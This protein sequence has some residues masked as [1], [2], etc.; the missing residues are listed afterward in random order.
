MLNRMRLWLRANL[1]RRRMEREMREEMSAHIERSTERLVK[2]G[3]SLDEARQQA[4]REFGNVPY[5]QEEARYA[6]GTIWLDAL[7][8]DARFAFRHFGR[9]PVTTVV[10]F[11]VLAIGMSISTLLFSFV[12]SYATQPPVGVAADDDLVR[13]RGSRSAGPAGRGV[14]AFS[15][16]EFLAYRALSNQFS[17]VAGWTDVP[18]ALIDDSDVERRVQ[19]ARVSFVTDNYFSVLGVRPVLGRGL[20]TSTDRDSSTDAVAVIG[21][22]AW[23]HL[24]GRDP[25]V[26]GSTM[27]VNGVPV[28]VVGIAPE[29]FVGMTGHRRLQ[30]WMPLAA[31]RQLVAE[32]P[33]SFRAFA[34]LRPGVTAQQATA[35]VHA[36]AVRT[37]DTPEDLRAEEPASD[38]VPLLAANG[39]PMFDRDVKLQTFSVGLLSL[40]VL[41]VTCT[42]VSALLTG[43]AN[44]RRQEIAIRLSLGA[45]RKRIMRQLLTESAVLAAA[46]A[47]AALGIVWL[48]LDTATRM[49]PFIPMRVA[50]TWPATAFTFGVALTV[51]VLFGL[52]PALHAT[53][54]ALATALRDSTAIVAASRARLQRGLVVAQIAFTQ[55]LIVLLAATLLFVLSNFQSQGRSQHPEHVIAL[56]VRPTSQI[57]SQMGEA[58]GEGDEPG[59]RTV[60]LPSV[61]E[62]QLRSAMRELAE[63]LRTMQ[64]VDATV[65][66][67]G[68]GFGLGTFVAHDDDRVPG[69]TQD[70]VGLFGQYAESGFFAIHDV[71]MLRGR[72]F[73]PAEVSH[74]G[75]VQTPVIISAPLARRLW[76]DVDPIGRRLRPTT[77]VPEAG[78]MLVVVGVTDDPIDE[79]KQQQDDYRVFLPPDTARTPTGLLVR[80]DVPAAP[81]MTGFRTIV[82]DALPGAVIN[83]R[84]LAD[85]EAGHARRYRIVTTSILTAGMM[86]LLLS[87]LG[88]Y[89]VIAFAVGQ[90]TREIAVRMAI[91]GA[92]PQIARSFLADGLRLSAMG[93]ALGLPV[94]LLGL[95]ALLGVSDDMPQVGLASVTI[96]VALGVGLVATAAAWIPAQRAVGVDPA[97]T[98]R[99]E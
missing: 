81:L 64:R 88:L 16:E 82:E 45:A 78:G 36:I 70:A 8:A 71:A 73:T 10:M 85:I 80:T 59:Q 39:D 25:N 3:M 74:G 43:L 93:L 4:T 79:A 5:L 9:R 1:L 53:R 94:S 22:D 65:I 76:A 60:A 99:S 6:R 72:E 13:I 32:L 26:I 48:V 49:L 58:R 28:T 24:F 89:A 30:L 77:N 67:Y 68:G 96:V 91:G 7:A 31:H 62:Q 15:G 47:A 23:D 33:E 61:G 52:S 35:A 46:A 83:A 63:R 12:H 51:G 92:G 21:H 56:D 2:R 37:V 90:R 38:V 55:P 57:T 69:I 17:S 50:I 11:V 19:E 41:L 14:R 42:N 34:R 84:T 95:R 75:D 98:L 29:G 54:L 87:A 27:T 86:A 40:L 20:T 18:V 44:A 97:I 66:N